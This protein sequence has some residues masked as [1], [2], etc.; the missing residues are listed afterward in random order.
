[1]NERL[2]HLRIKIKSLVAE[3]QIIREEARKTNGDVKW[4][5]NQHRKTIV[6]KVTRENLLAY[7][8]LKGIPY[9]VMEGS[10]TTKPDW[11]EIGAIARR[12]GGSKDVLADWIIEAQAHLHPAEV[13]KASMD[14]LKLVRQIAS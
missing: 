14:T 7:G 2:I 8:L 3:S 11:Q 12:F 4:G 10:T 1:M 6:R 5:L 9:R 13:G